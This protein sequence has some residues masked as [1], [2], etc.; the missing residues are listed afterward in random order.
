M[1]F[2]DHSEAD[3]DVLRQHADVEVDVVVFKAGVLLAHH[4]LSRDLL[5]LLSRNLSDVVHHDPFDLCF[6]G[7]D[8]DLLIVALLATELLV[9]LLRGA[10][11]QQLLHL[12]HLF[13]VAF[14]IVDCLLD[15]HPVF[16]HLSLMRK[17]LFLHIHHSFN[18]STHGHFLDNGQNVDTRFLE[19]WRHIQRNIFY[20]FL[21]LFYLAY[22][23]VFELLVRTQMPLMP[24]CCQ[25]RRSLTFDLVQAA[26]ATFI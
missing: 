16:E 19:S 22:S 26:L 11:P 2:G 8:L 15:L 7:S 21:V 18:L 6:G 23:P 1:L 20:L 5:T 25:G 10:I 4:F 24:L 12:C 9:I 3:F 13:V 14:L 17:F